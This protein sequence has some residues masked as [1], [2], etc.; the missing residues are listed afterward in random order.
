MVGTRRLSP[1]T[2]V[3]FFLTVLLFIGMC[4]LTVLEVRMRPLIMA[5]AEGLARTFA[6]DALTRAVDASLPGSAEGFVTVLS[7]ENGVRSV[8]CDMLAAAKVRTAAAKA[9]REALSDADAMTFE[10]PLG[11]L[12]GSHF[13]TGRGAMIPIRLIPVSDVS[14]D[15][16]T[17][18][19]ES[20][21]NQTL[22]R[23]L[24]KIDV[25]V[26]MLVRS[27][28]VTIRLTNSLCLAE[29]VIVGDVPE[30]YTAINRFEVD[31]GEENDLN[32]YGAQLP[33]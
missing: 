27:D 4:V 32:D 14:A 5:G 3:L 16:R 20:G 29:T 23:L 13:L 30:A 18:F 12:T 7:D 8:E 31:E 17:E 28:S 21:I 24:L 25:T 11:S 26:R 15:L 33:G 10:V 2:L 22:H 6:A 19:I 1:F 9:A